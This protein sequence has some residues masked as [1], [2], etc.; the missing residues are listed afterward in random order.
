[1]NNESNSRTSQEI[2]PTLPTAS[3][4]SAGCSQPSQLASR[5]QILTNHLPNLTKKAFRQDGIMAPSDVSNL[6]NYADLTLDYISELL[7][8]IADL[9][10]QLS[11]LQ[12]TRPPF[13]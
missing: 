8:Q 2:S 12:H 10:Q 6:A 13:I 11:D 5:Y 4:E 7:D 3:K 9:Q 1:M